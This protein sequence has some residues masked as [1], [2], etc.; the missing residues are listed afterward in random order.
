LH[1]PHHQPVG[2]HQRRRGRQQQQHAPRGAHHPAL[3]PR[4][5][6]HGQEQP[7]QH[8]RGGPPAAGSQQQA[9]DDFL[10][11]REGEEPRG[12]GENRA[13]LTPNIRGNQAEGLPQEPAAGRVARPHYGPCGRP[14]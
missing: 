7:P 10:G 11:Q 13:H 14:A 8:P 6:P 3:E 9:P 1:V 4:P 12:Q 5:H 2:Q